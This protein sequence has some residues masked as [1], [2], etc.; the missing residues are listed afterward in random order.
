MRLSIRL[1]SL[2]LIVFASGCT[3]FHAQRQMTDT[4]TS[5][6]PSSAALP[7]ADTSIVD[8]FSRQ[9]VGVKQATLIQALE[10][11]KIELASQG[12]YD[13]CVRPGCNECVIQTGECHCRVGVEKGGPC[14]GECTAA[15]IDDRGNVPGVDK[16]QILRNLGCYR[17]LYEGTGPGAEPESG[18]GTHHH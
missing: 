13:C 7:D 17:E 6:E 8:E 4:T 10:A 9:P 15:W 3:A 2:L 14:C 5:R 18:A 11:Y 1:V 12:K 16:E